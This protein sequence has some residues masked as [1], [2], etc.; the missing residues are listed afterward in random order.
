MTGVGG[1]GPGESGSPGRRIGPYEQSLRESRERVEA[2]ARRRDRHRRRVRVA[3]AAAIAVVVAGLGVAA[4]RFLGSSEVPTALPTTAA[5]PTSCSD[6]VKVRVSAAPAIAPA[7]AAV[8]ENLAKRP[9]GPCAA[10]T[11][12]S[13][14]PYAVA[15]S[16]VGAGRP[17]A[18]VTD[19]A[20]WSNRASSISGAALDAG[21]PFASSAV[22]LA[23]KDS[24]ASA[25]GTRLGWADLLGG[26]VQVRIPDPRRSATGR[27]AVTVATPLVP[28]S[29]LR[30]IASAG[31]PPPGDGALGEVAGSDGR[32]GAAV[33]QAELVAWNTE[34]PDRSLAAVAPAEGAPAV[35]YSLVSLTTDAAKKPLVAALAK[36]L[37]S[38]DS[39]KLL[40]DSGFRTTGGEPA[41]PSPLYGTIS[42]AGRAEGAPL[43]KATA[44]W[45]A[46]SKRTRALLAVDVSGSMLER[47][48]EGKR[49]DVLQRATVR[50]VG[51]ANP[52]TLASLWIYSQHIGSRGDDVRQLIDYAP[53][54]DA[55]RVADFDKAV[56]GLD[57]FAGG[58]SGLYDTIASSY[59]R[60]RSTWRAGYTNT[61]VVVADGPNDDD[62]G[63]TLDLLEK[64]LNA[65]KDASRP[66][67]VVVLGLGDRVDAAALRRVVAITGG[68]YVASPSLDR[69]QPAL[70]TALG[71]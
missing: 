70:V 8:A 41:N 49:L 66:V 12:D 61:V 54:G 24:R 26:P 71:G 7:L 47:D 44:L 27:A 35:D 50:A 30:T 18:W 65:A 17:D 4:Y 21:E 45:T 51:G 31:P 1:P 59:D 2:A 40:Q 62:Y 14:E 52:D 34:H 6:P 58:G 9:D 23:M 38:D 10:F 42:V 37:A 28:E 19:S 32:I 64:R 5:Q 39:R 25:L 13:D 16:L 68:Q 48:T 33:T 53:L 36:H 55:K 15:G 11:I 29:R 57:S 63:L 46:V 69:L 3:G 20:A 56:A 67:P 60:A 22:V 43:A